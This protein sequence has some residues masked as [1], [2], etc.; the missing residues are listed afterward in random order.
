MKEIQF[1]IIGLSEDEAPRSFTAA[2][3][4]AQYKLLPEV[5]CTQLGNVHYYVTSFVIISGNDCSPTA[6]LWTDI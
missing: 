2:I 6:L 5:K 1:F 4:R 3:N